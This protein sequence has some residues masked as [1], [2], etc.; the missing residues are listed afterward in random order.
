M[1]AAASSARAPERVG[2]VWFTAS[3]LRLAARVLMPGGV[4]TVDDV[5]NEG[6]PGVR[7]A[8]LEALAGTGG[9][10]ADGPLA[11]APFATN[12]KCFLTTPAH[13]ALLLNLT[14]S[15]LERAG[16]GGDLVELE[17]AGGPFVWPVLHIKTEFD[18]PLDLF[19]RVVNEAWGL[20]T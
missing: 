5:K 13:H 7:A 3:D 20:K 18:A 10:A 1:S 6:W 16:V 15:A 9:A 2:V 8:L 11:L 19:E 12:F 4:V 14:R 17:P